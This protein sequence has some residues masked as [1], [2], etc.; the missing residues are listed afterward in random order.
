MRSLRNTG[1]VRSGVPWIAHI[2]ADEEH[3][4]PLQYGKSQLGLL[5]ET[6][7]LGSR[8]RLGENSC[9]QVVLMR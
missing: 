3:R 4:I 5:V 7:F 6:T 9:L 1:S 8:T 2:L